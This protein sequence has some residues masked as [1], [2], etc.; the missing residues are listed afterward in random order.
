MSN[1]P[2]SLFTF[3]S[4]FCVLWDICAP[5]G[6]RALPGQ[7]LPSVVNNPFL[8]MKSGVGVWFLLL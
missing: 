5:V 4:H 7:F 3:F 8:K 2:T 6:G 1:G